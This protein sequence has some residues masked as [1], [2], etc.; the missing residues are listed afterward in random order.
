MKQLTFTHIAM[1]YI[2]T[3]LITTFFAAASAEANPLKVFIIR[4]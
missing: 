2:A 3:L 4:K 1:K